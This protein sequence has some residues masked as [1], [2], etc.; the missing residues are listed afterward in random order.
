MIDTTAHIHFANFSSLYERA[1]QLT[2][3]SK[4][5]RILVDV[6]GRDDL[7]VALYAWALHNKIEVHDVNDLPS[8]QEYG[9]I[10]LSS[11]YNLAGYATAIA[12]RGVL[13]IE[14]IGNAEGVTFTADI[15]P[16]A[17]CGK[18][19]L[20]MHHKFVPE[21]RVIIHWP[22][23]NPTPLTERQQNDGN[24]I[25]RIANPDDG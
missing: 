23:E 13:L 12:D 8:E 6:Q 2:D 24:S 4:C 10:W 9:L 21:D 1:L 15:R 22:E 14:D 17:G 18:A 19:C 7:I 11:K 3:Y 25:D 5:R 16:L 20:L